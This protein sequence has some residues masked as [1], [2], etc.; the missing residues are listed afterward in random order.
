MNAAEEQLRSWAGK[1]DSIADR[2]DK[3]ESTAAGNLRAAK[4]YVQEQVGRIHHE[5]QDEM[6]NRT[7]AME[8]R[9][10]KAEAAQEQDRDQLA[11][12]RQEV[13]TLRSDSAQQL[14]LSQ[15]ENGRELGN[16]RREIGQ[17]REVFEDFA[18]H[19]EVW[20]ADFE[21]YRERR[22]EIA[23]GLAV[24]IANANVSRQ[25]ISGWLHL[26]ADGKILWLR[27]QNIHQPV[28]FRNQRD[29][30][31][32]ELV[33]TRIGRDSAVG[34]VIAPRY[35]SSQKPAADQAGTLPEMAVR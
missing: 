9:I 10:A 6:N 18:R 3:A 30:Q 35:P 24:T 33:F 31:A 26:V 7:R 14:A 13:G 15:Q 2:L 11:A 19:E 22:Q 21:V 17:N 27:D 25:Q 12:L 8:T 23:P 4:Y 34:Y 28:M 5:I 32:Y 16:L 20:R 29:D 1:W